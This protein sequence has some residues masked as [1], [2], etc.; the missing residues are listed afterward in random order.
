MKFGG[1]S[2]GSAQAMS[3]AA[4]IVENCPRR[5][6][7]SGGGHICDFRRDQPFIG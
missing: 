3:D 7:A 4:Q 1:T 5:M 6:A 2:V